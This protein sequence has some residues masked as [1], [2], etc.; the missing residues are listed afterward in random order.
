[1]ESYLTSLCTLLPSNVKD[2]EITE[3]WLHLPTMEIYDE[4]SADFFYPWVLL[5][6]F[7]IQFKSV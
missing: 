7:M 6:M 3:G 4:A 5:E 1:M 2:K